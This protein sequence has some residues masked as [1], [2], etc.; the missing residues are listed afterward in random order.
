MNIWYLSAHDQPKGQSARTYEFCQE[1]LKRGHK[2][3]MFTNSYCHWTHKELLEPG[4]KWRIE[5]IEGMRVIWLRTIHYTGNGMKRG[6]NMISNAWRSLQVAKTLPD[7]PDV[8]VGPTVPLGTGWAAA[9]IAQQKR[10]AF[11]FEVR[12]VWPIALV[13]DG[14]LSKN[15]PVYYAFRYLEK[16]LYKKAHRIS[17]TM[18]FVFNH[19]AE[20]GSD[21]TKVTW[22][23]NGVNFERFTD[24][25]G[26]DGGTKRP[27]VAMYIGGFGNAHDVITIVRAA[28]ILQEKGIDDVRFVIIGDGVKKSECLAEAEAAHLKNLEFRGS[29]PK[30]DIPRVQME[31]DILIAAVLD[32]PIYRFGLNLNKMFDY[33]ASER[34]VVFSGNA[35]ND[36]VVEAGAGFSIPPEQPEAMAEV[37]LRLLDMT[38]EER[39]QM[40]KRGRSWVEKDFDMRM[41]GERMEYLLLQAIKERK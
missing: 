6:A 35:P 37:L 34:P 14:G 10:A 25:G 12:D 16:W 27:L 19:I 38:P 17:A 36:P 40:G 15:H 21:P 4:E 9:R 7:W 8:V 31:S 20:S 22:V 1:L 2:V 28:K 29:I 3:T 11:V 33:F 39:L 13:D 32:S 24:Y 30:A 18:P 23:P 26:Y 41:L 5:D